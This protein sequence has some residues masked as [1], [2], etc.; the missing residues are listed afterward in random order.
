M[1]SI[2]QIDSMLPFSN[3]SQMTSKC[4][5]N[6]KRFVYRACYIRGKIVV[7]SLKVKFNLET[8]FILD[9]ISLDCRVT[10]LEYFF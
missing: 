3:R 10:L 4:G 5:K 8:N 6:N 2:Q 9:L 7:S 1:F